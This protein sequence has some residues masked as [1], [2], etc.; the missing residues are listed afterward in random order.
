MN[1]FGGRVQ[2]GE[3][4]F[5]RVASGDGVAYI[6][7]IGEIDMTTGDHLDQAL[8]RVLNEPGVSQLMLDLAQL[9]FMD[10]NGVSLLVTAQR[11]AHA[12]GIVLGILNVQDPV[13]LVLETLGV[14]SLLAVEDQRG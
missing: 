14:Y 4:R 11:T 10:S 5:D 13:R 3:L 2:P 12:R 7:L 9:W 1:T 6:A 8:A